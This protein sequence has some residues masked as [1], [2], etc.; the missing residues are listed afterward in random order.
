MAQPT[1]ITSAGT[2]GTIAEGIFF[3]QVVVAED[4]DGGALTY[5]LIA[6]SLPE[7]IQVK[8]DGTLEGVPV[9]STVVQGVPTQVSEDVE[10]SFVI[11]ATSEDNRINDRTFSLTVTGADAPEFV[12]PAGRVGTFFDGSQ[13][14]ITIQATDVDPGDTF[15]F[16]LNSGSLPPGLELNEATGVISGVIQPLSAL[17]GNALSG[18]DASGFDQYAFDFTARSFNQNFQFTLEVTDGILSSVR[19]FEI[20]V[21][22]NAAMTS[23]DSQDTSDDSFITSDVVPTYLPIITTPTGDLGTYRIDNY[24][25]YKFDTVNFNNKPVE[26][27]LNTGSLPPGLTLTPTGFLYGDFPDIGTVEVTYEFALRVKQIDELFIAYNLLSAYDTDDVV[28]YQGNNYQALEP[29]SAGVL[30]TNTAYWY[31]L[32]SPVSADYN[33]TITFIGNI[34]STVTWSNNTLVSGSTTVYDMGSIA[35]GE[36]SVLEVEASTLDNRLLFYRLKSG[37]D[38]RLPQGLS[39]LSSGNISGRVSFNGFSLDSGTTTLDNDLSTRLEVDQ[40]TFDSVFT[41][42]VNAYSNDGLVSVFRTFQITVDREYNTPYESLYIQAMPNAQDRALIDSLV[43]NN[44]IFVPSEIYRYD[45]PFFGVS[46]K[47]IYPHAYGLTASSLESYVESLNL[48]HFRKRLVLGDIRTAQALDSNGDVLYEVVYANIVDDGVNQQGESPPQSVSTAFPIIGDDISTETSTVYPN[49][50]INMR[51]QVIDNIE[52]ISA[53]LP[54]WMTSKQTDGRVLGFTKAWVIAYTNPGLS[55][56][57]AYNVR[58]QFG[59]ILN[60]ID[61]MADRYII[62][63][64]LT[65]NWEPFDDSTA[66]GKWADAL[67]TTFNVDQD[68]NPTGSGEPTIFDAGSVRFVKPVDVYE[69]TDKYNE[70][71][72][73]PKYNILGNKEDEQHSTGDPIVSGGITI[74]QT[75]SA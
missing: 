60:R 33:Y 42:T 50:L 72:L 8:T 43:L 4:P 63:R 51:T 14:E 31:R 39:L 17:P 65:K 59:Q 61:F 28:S 19:E 49:S 75:V 55:E 22:S 56:K 40:T 67:Q 45:D 52:Q 16:S 34:E 71:I 57:V 29:V 35:N 66:S 9:A 36:L 68:V 69:F 12:T 47:V 27:F 5:S 20:Y 18:F 3:S 70:Y 46:R 21:Y 15:T 7:G 32:D 44:D 23:D 10:S 30:P 62:D 54:R 1:W 11:R 73:F 38:S 24:F 26:V 58:T 41:F 6:G 2:L 48:N 53:E 37:S 13:A 74:E 64:L 25:I